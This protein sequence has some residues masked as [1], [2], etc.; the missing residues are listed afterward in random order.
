[1]SEKKNLWASLAAAAVAAVAMAGAP[2]AHASS[3]PLTTCDLST[4][5]GAAGTTYGSVA[6]TNITGGVQVTLTLT[7]GDVFNFGGAGQPLMFELSGA[8]TI[9]NISDPL[10]ANVSFAAK[11]GTMMDD[12][13][14]TWTNWIQC[15]SGCGNGTNNAIPAALTFD[16]MGSGFSFALN[17]PA[18]SNAPMYFGTDIGIPTSP[19]AKTYYTGD[20]GATTVVPLPPSAAL[21][22]SALL[23]V[24]L[25]L[26]QRSRSRALLLPAL[27]AG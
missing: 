7:A 23:L 6:V 24:G 26:A 1:V 5:C 17:T 15:K 27:L 10:D 18:G 16:V 8:G 22:G 25:L 21:F 3:Y 12:G 2:C 11:S 20:V 19:G 13:T 4:G 14:G 9:T